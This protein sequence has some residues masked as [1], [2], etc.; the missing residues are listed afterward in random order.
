MAS[1]PLYKSLKSKGTSFYAFPG[2]AEDI[3]AAYQNDNYKMYFS[4]YI[5]LNFPKQNTIA[6]TLSN[7]TY[8][9]FDTS[10]EKSPNAVP[11]TDF[12][13]SIIESLRNYVAN[14]ETVIRES[15]LN[16]TE[17]F[18]DTN[19]L[20]TTSEKIFWKWCKK[21]NIID[22]EPA[23]PDDEYFSSLS[24]FTSRN[25]NDD[26]Y[27]PEF[28]W[29]EREVEYWSAVD[30]YQSASVTFPG[31]LEVEFASSTNFRVG[32]LVNINN[33]S[34]TSV[35]NN[36]APFGYNANDGL[37][38]TVLE[39]TPVSATQ[40]Q[41]IIFDI[42]AYTGP[43]V[44]TGGQVGLV[45][46]VYHKLVQYIGEVN[47]LSNV[48]E[49]NRSYTEVYANIPDHTGQTP[50]IL[51]RTIVDDNY[52]PNLTFPIIPSQFQ[53]EIMGAELFNSPIVSTPQNYPGSYFGQFDTINYTYETE[54]GDSLRRSGRYFGVSGDINNPIIDGSTVD[55]VTVD[56]NIGH[57]VKMNLPRRAITN[58]DQFNAQ[59]V[60]NEPPIDFE[61]NAILWYYTVEGPDGV[62]RQNLY[63][64]SFFDNPA[65]NPVDEEVGLRFP[66]YKKLV[67]NGQQDGT[68]YSFSLNLN[69]NIINENTVDAYNPQAINSL[70]SMNLFNES[71]RRLAAIND[72]FLNIVAE[73][74]FLR[75]EIQNLKSLLYTQTD[76]NVLNQKITTLESLLRLYATNQ[77]V[78]SSTIKVTQI[79][80]NPP[81][82]QLDNIDTQYVSVDTYNTSILFNSQGIIPVNLGVPENKN[83]LIQVLN[84][85]EVEF[86]LPNEERLTLILSR[87]LYLR[88]SVDFLITGTEL[89]SQN[90]KLD[91]YMISD[92]TTIPTETLIIGEI[93][94]PVFFNTDTQL[95]NSAYRWKEFNFEIDTTQ[96][97]N[98]LPNNLLEVPFTGNTYLLNNSIKSGDVLVLNN[99]FVGTASVFD[100]SGQ[101]TVDSVIGVTSSYVN[102]DISS[103][104]EF[105]AFAASQSLPYN[106]HSATYSI[107]SNN[108]YFSLNK[109][110]KIR[111]TRISDS[112]ILSERYYIEITDIN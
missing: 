34:L 17:Y 69:F 81:S 59:T 37:N 96:S 91:I 40:G 87:D 84:N 55:G 63:G 24:E 88:Q 60:N 98:I 82:F 86:T 103:N 106:L 12:S 46:L 100:F 73:N 65:N 10:F 77:I 9:D 39:I 66:V 62:Q 35:E 107:L 31:Y 111:L 99:L 57:Y 50:D 43:S 105:V 20:Y 48:Q 79:P 47:G 71:M 16:N 92:V 56:F 51:F 8:F 54:T 112:S 27:F 67:S 83:F 49:A 15:R 52:A 45:N 70:F 61:F 11:T 95:Q 5:L 36:L 23:V 2:A 6:G 85:D 32:D 38:T 26:E 109:G 72:S 104:N 80:G 29:K 78:D 19:A 13:E 89:A 33:V 42:P 22:F 74:Q 76:I 28:L 25:I 90:K 93:D 3:S 4:K 44:F 7:P 75:D 101:Y 110:K 97:I 41:K 18:Y 58:F 108:P 102:F 14:Q 53:P 94:L 30:F 21:L 68:A 1:T 64:V